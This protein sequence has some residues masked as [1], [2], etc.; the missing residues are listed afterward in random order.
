VLAF[1]GTMCGSGF[2]L[3]SQVSHAWQLLIVFGLIVGPGMSTHGVVT[4][5]V[6]ARWFQN[7][8]GTMTGIE[9][10]G[11]AAGQFIIPPIAAVLLIAYGWR[12]TFMMMGFAA[13]VMLLFAA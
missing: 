4:L 12:F 3:L 7:R 1:T 13:I 5:S 8:C 2:V 6:I 10:V 9:K 11:M